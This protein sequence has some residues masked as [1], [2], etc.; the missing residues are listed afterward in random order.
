VLLVTHTYM[1][2]TKSQRIYPYPQAVIL[3]EKATCMQFMKQN[4]C[5]W[6]APADVARHRF[7]QNILRQRRVVKVSTLPLLKDTR[8]LKPLYK[9]VILLL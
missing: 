1:H 5:C 3:Y 6:E 2:K 9:F 4:E 7:I 8:H